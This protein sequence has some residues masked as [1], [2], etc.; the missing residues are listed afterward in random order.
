LALP[1]FPWEK[2]LGFGTGGGGASF[3]CESPLYLALPGFRKRKMLWRE[4]GMMV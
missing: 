2:E 3:F 4:A 1:A